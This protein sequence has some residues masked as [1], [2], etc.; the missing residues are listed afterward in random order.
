MLRNRLNQ[1]AIGILFATSAIVIPA[2]AK[3]DCLTDNLNGLPTDYGRKFT[4]TI[5][6]GGG[7]WVSWSPGVMVHAG[8]ASYSMNQ[9]F[10]DRLSGSQMFNVG[11]PDSHTITSINSAT[12]AVTV[13][14]N[15]W[16]FNWGFT[17][18]C[19]NGSMAHWS[20]S[21]SEVIVSFGSTTYIIP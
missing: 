3:A 16:N 13:H 4:M 2:A 14:N 8:N 19:I 5:V 10:S 18:S 17:L 1:V 12:G 7:S 9:Y 6:T 20:D 11:A 21:G 15:T